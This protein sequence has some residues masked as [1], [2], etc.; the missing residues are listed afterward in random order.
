M[1]SIPFMIDLLYFINRLSYMKNKNFN[2][3]FFMKFHETVASN[4]LILYDL[5]HIQFGLKHSSTGINV[6]ELATTQSTTL[7]IITTNVSTVSSK[8]MTGNG[9]IF[10]R[11]GSM[12]TQKWNKMDQFFVPVIAS[13]PK[14]WI[15]KRRWFHPS[16]WFTLW[17][18]N[19]RVNFR[20]VRTKLTRLD[21]L[22]NHF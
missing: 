22:I 4:C 1:A 8:N 16:L 5:I 7:Q 11:N 9:P 17:Q 18:F 20:G 6:S 14:R 12:I 3:W 21:Y 19:H 13:P 10:T 15:V 2:A